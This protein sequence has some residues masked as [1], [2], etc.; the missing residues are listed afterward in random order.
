MS[1]IRGMIDRYGVT[2]TPFT[3]S[4]STVDAGGAVIRSWTAGTAFTMFLQPAMP[5]ESGSQVHGVRRSTLA[6]PATSR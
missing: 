6:A 5:R 4:D 1:N 3:L 2:V